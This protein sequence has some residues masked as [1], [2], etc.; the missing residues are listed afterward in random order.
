[1][2]H[3]GALNRAIGNHLIIEPHFCESIP[4]LRPTDVEDNVVPNAFL[5]RYLSH[6]MSVDIVQ[7]VLQTDTR[8]SI[9]GSV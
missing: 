6:E 2:V 4:I 9:L 7:T 1:M 3:V 5:N 8:H